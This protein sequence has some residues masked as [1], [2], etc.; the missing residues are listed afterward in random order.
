[1]RSVFA[2]TFH[3]L[4]LLEADDAHHPERLEV[5]PR[6]MAENCHDRL[7]AAGGGR[8]LLPAPR[9]PKAPRIAWEGLNWS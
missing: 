6:E 3:F 2:D 7:R 1:M 4:A 8:R 5:S 9:H